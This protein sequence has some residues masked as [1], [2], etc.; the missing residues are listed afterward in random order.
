M[1][2]RY[3]Y[4]RYTTETSRVAICH[5][6]IPQDWEVENRCVSDKVHQTYETMK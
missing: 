5:K 2:A 6:V 4:V 1:I 3:D